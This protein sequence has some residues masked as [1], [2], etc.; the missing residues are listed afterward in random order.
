[1]RPNR[2]NVRVYG[3]LFN[4]QNEVLLTDELRNGFSMTKFPGGGLEFG[5][6][7]AAGLQREFQEELAL[8]IQVDNLFYIN[9]FLQISRFNPTDQL[10]SVYY[11]VTALS[12]V[13]PLHTVPL[14]FPA[15]VRDAQLFRWHAVSALN[16]GDFTFP[17][18]RVVADKL[19]RGN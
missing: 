18:D 12:P 15:G 5:E 3:L 4:G 2:Y 14:D 8:D 17:I 13:G 16:P 1:M 11:K 6:G 7:L 19:L 9:D 10:L